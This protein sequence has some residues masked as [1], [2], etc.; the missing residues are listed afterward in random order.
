MAY[1]A[2]P[3]DL[4]TQRDVL[5]ALWEENLSDPGIA[6]AKERR[7]TWLYGEN[8]AGPSRTFLVNDDKDGLIGCAS[9]YPRRVV[10]GAHEV[11]AGVLSDFA[12]K[13][14]HRAAG[15]AVT[16]QRTIA[17]AAKEESTAL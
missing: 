3:L 16:V 10:F 15:A 11:R 9:A 2:Q 5:T 6:T 4:D 8:P 17:Q 1:V 12:V 14:A 13:R 7:V